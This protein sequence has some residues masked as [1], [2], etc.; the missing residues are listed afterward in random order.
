MTSN[1]QKLCLFVQHK[2]VDHAVWPNAEHIVDDSDCAIYQY[3]MP[4]GGRFNI[5]INV[6]QKH[7]DQGFLRIKKIELNGVELHGLPYFS[8]YVTDSGRVIHN[9]YGYMSDTGTY[10]IHIR[11]NALVHNYMSSLINSL[12]HSDE[13][14][15]S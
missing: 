8:R 10:F 9:A 15:H 4:I 2:A 12:D 1:T 14:Q 6:T 13:I 5:K 11:Q 7:H 3:P